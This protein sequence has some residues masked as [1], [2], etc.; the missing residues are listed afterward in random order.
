MISII[1]VLKYQRSYLVKRNLKERASKL[2]E[3]ARKYPTSTTST[4]RKRYSNT[5]IYMIWRSTQSL[6]MRKAF[7]CLEDWD[8][9]KVECSYLVGKN[10]NQ[11]R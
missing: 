6:F 9:S 2:R 8:E 5:S 7:Q 4:K 10:L 11:G 3:R 1:Y